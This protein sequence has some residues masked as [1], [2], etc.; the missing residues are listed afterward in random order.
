MRLHGVWFLLYMSFVEAFY[1]RL[2]IEGI[3][4]RDVNGLRVITNVGIQYGQISN[5]SLKI[6]IIRF[7]P[8]LHVTF[9]FK[10][11]I[12]IPPLSLAWTH[13]MQSF[14]GIANIELS[15]SRL[16]GSSQKTWH[17]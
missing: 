1:K 12:G 8:P 11:C 6:L 5:M 4:Y 16:H 14:L 13:W 9:V 10:G 15:V 2:P 17:G 7:P 3:W